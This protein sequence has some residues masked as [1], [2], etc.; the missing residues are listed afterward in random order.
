[1][2]ALDPDAGVTY[3]GKDSTYGMTKRNEY[4][5]KD[6]HQPSDEVK[7]DWDLTG[8]VDDARVLFRVGYA[9][10]QRDALPQWREGNEFR[11]KRDSMMKQP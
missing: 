8:A 10:A 5:D 2:P 1:M 11:A 3:V 9:V 6:Y 7:A 4:N